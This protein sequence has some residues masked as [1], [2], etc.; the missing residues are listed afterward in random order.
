MLLNKD[1]Q[2]A[3]SLYSSKCYLSDPF[4]TDGE[5]H[6]QAVA[7]YLFSPLILKPQ[8]GLQQELE[9]NFIFRG[10]CTF[11]CVH[12]VGLSLLD[13][14][15]KKVFLYLSGISFAFICPLSIESKEKNKTGNTCLEY[16]CRKRELTS[17]MASNNNTTISGPHP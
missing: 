4:G 15:S 6:P 8:Q 9:L 7:K 10:F 3:L 11:L 12:S 1:Q 2:L 14:A 16:I 17:S 13:S 5:Y